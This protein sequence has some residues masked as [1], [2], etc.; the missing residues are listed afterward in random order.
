MPDRRP[1]VADVRIDGD[2]IGFQGHEC[3]PRQLDVEIINQAITSGEARQYVEYQAT[4][5]RP[6][7][8]VSTAWRR[9]AGF[10]QPRG[11]AF[12]G[13]RDRSRLEIEGARFLDFAEGQRTDAAEELRLKLHLGVAAGKHGAEDHLLQRGADE[14]R[15]WRRIS[16]IQCG[17]SARASERPS[18][19]LATIILVSPNSSR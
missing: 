18:S 6:R 7:V 17:P 16:T 2:S 3:A 19:G 4:S 10:A 11:P 14:S 5:R 1:A 9:L 13:T 15:A 12:P 8:H